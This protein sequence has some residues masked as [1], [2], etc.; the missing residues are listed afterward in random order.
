ML[1]SGA[2]VPASEA[3][4][5][6]PARQIVDTPTA[7]MN[8][9]GSFETRAQV[10]PG[11]GVALELEVGLAHWLSVGG[12]Y[13]GLQII[14]DGEPDWY[15]QPGFAVKARLVQETY[16]SPAFAL[17]VDTQGSGYWDA[18]RERFQYKSRGFYGVVSK[19]YEWLGDLSLHG[20]LSRSLEDTDDRDPTGF[21][22]LEKSLGTL[23]GLSVEYDLATNDNRDDGAYG[24]GRGYL[25]GVLRWNV[26][27]RMEI[28]LVVRDMLSNSETVDPSDSDVVVDEGWGRE[29]SFSY[30]ET[31]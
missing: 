26:D 9:A 28:R 31:F 2:V 12:A 25:N 6:W 13:G 27:P 21:V 3:Q 5:A 18:G 29:F 15:P 8:Q 17:G 20:G 16:Y 22:G 14:G 7:G 24:K 23:L 4:V 11:G 1:C 30:V 19:N 10:F